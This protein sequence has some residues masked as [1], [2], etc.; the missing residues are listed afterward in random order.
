MRGARADLSTPPQARAVAGITCAAITTSAV[1]LL[2]APPSIHL[3]GRRTLIRVP[4]CRP[5]S[6]LNVTRK[7]GHNGSAYVRTWALV[8]KPVASPWQLRVRVRRRTRTRPYPSRA[9]R[10]RGGDNLY[11]ELAASRRC[12]THVDMDGP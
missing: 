3:L 2:L 11:S 1:G 7:N 4:R 8:R 5:L 6:L 10:E 12:G 9:K